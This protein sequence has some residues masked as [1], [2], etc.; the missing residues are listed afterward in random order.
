MNRRPEARTFTVEALL[1][2]AQEGRIRLPDLQRPPRWRASH[3]MDFFDSLYRGFPVGQLLL[4]QQRAEA[5]LLSFGPVHLPGPAMEGAFFVVDGQQ[6]LTALAGALLHPDA[7]PR[8]DIHALWFDLAEEKFQRARLREP[9]PHWIPL[10]VAGDSFKLLNWLKDWPLRTECS[11]LVQ[12]AILLGKVLREYPI[13]VSIIQG[14]SEEVLRLAFKRLNTSGV[15]MKEYEVFSSHQGTTESRRI[16]SAC[17]RLAQNGSGLIETEWFLRC[18]EAVEGQDAR[19]S[20]GAGEAASHRPPP[21]A[22]EH[23]EVALRRALVFLDEDAGIPH[24]RLM[25]YVLLPLVVLARF[26]HLHPHP[27][28]R[29]R[30][31]LARWL[32]RGAVSGVH[33]DC[34]SRMLLAHQQSIDP[35]DESTSLKRLLERVPRELDFPDAS[36]PWSLQSARTRLCALALLHLRP[37]DV[38]TGKVLDLEELLAPE[39]DETGEE[40]VG[41]LFHSVS[42]REQTSV[43]RYVLL[44]APQQLELLPEAAPEVLRSHAMDAAAAE[45]LRRQ[46]FE[47]FERYRARV[48]NEWLQRFFREQCAVDESDR[49]AI[50]H[51]LRQV[52]EKAASL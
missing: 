42:R 51:L 38:A 35:A 14:A 44:A 45:A 30:R 49:P 5:E 9:P 31:L 33:A 41:R 52:E 40:D 19:K 48:L 39:A 8:G 34:D 29:T 1:Q 13:P 11:D 32:W 43:A 3:V 16:G 12:R 4:S 36:T 10:N 26:F 47:A 37:R 2:L 25:P 27:H 24:I 20:N 46:D 6:R 18:A 15:G 23:T 17:A 22:I 50:A 28:P 7:R 21:G